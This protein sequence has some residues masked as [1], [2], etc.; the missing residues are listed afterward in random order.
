M[1]HRRRHIA[2]AIGLGIAAIALALVK[3]A[4]ADAAPVL[5]QTIDNTSVTD[6]LPNKLVLTV[7]AGGVAAGDTL[8]VVGARAICAQD[9]ASVPDALAH[10]DTGCR[11]FH[12][13]AR[14]GSS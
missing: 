9:V 1:T 6:D 13:P 5:V 4:P 10:A 3:P 7:P 2:A 11:H 12:G 8:V 14:H